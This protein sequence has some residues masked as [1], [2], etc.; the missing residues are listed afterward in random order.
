MIDHSPMASLDL[1]FDGKSFPVPK[2]L[3]FELFEHHREL[4]E[5][6]SYAVRSSVSLPVFEA[7]VDSLKTQTKPSVRQRNAASLSLLANE[8]FLSELA[9]ECAPFSVSVDQFSS[10]SERVSALE[11]QISSNQPSQ[12]EEKLQ[13]HENGLEALRLVLEKLK[14][15]LQ[16]HLTQ[17]KCDVGQLQAGSTP[18]PPSKRDKS[19]RQVEI[20]LKPAARIESSWPWEK[21]NAVQQENR[22]RLLAGVISYLTKKHSGNVHEK[23]IVTITSKSVSSNHPRDAL[24]NVAD[25]PALS[26]FESKN[27][28][29]QWICWDFRKMRV[30]L[31]HY[32][33]CTSLTKSWVI[34]GS[35]DGRSWTEIDHRTNNWDFERGGTAAF[36]ASYPAEVRFIRLTQTGKIHRV[37]DDDYYPGED[38]CLLMSAVEFFG[39]LFE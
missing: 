2:K 11:R 27:E 21:Q 17:L 9:A 8:F 1:V 35:L 5:A 32:T 4:F 38:Y 19:P 15:S 10:L 29:G 31:T 23:G 25:L 39:T 3:V 33:L 34:E 22:A 18:S 36:A 28:P 24:K 13:T 12:I 16:A 26:H 37:D 6:T 7:F 14:T 20:P 30:R